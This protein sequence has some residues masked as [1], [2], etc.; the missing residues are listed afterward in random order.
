VILCGA[1]CRGAA[2]LLRTISDRLKAPLVH[3]VRGKELMACDD[4]RW[5]GGLVMIGTKALSGN[6]VV[7][8][9]FR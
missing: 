5:M 7:N 9:R 3:T 2:E 8:H 6:K 4:S 1:G